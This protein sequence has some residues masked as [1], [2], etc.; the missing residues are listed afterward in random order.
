MDL[1]NVLGAIDV[2]TAFDGV[3][4]DAEGM[5]TAALPFIV[6]IFGAGLAITVGKKFF[7]KAS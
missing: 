4:T 5:V 7:R 6:G 2:A 1:L 3:A